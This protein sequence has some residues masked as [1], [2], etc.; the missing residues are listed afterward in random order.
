MY[1]LLKDSVKALLANRF[2]SFRAFYK[3]FFNFAGI[4]IFDHN[5]KE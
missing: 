2:I 3:G 5:I 4:T 1:F